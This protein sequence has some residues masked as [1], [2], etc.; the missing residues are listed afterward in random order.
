MIPTYRL[1]LLTIDK[2]SPR[3][4]DVSP[5]VWVWISAVIVYVV[6]GAL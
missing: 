3:L 1:D 4:K 5:V 2:P 6:W